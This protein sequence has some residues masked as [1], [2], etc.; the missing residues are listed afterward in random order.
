[1][2]LEVVAI[3]LL[4]LFCIFVGILIGMF[5]RKTPGGQDLSEDLREIQ[6]R[7]EEWQKIAATQQQIE[8][9]RTELSNAHVTLS[10][11]DTLI[12]NLT[13]FTQQNF[14]PEVS[15]Q[16]QAAMTNITQVQQILTDVLQN[17]RQETSNTDQRHAQLLT[18]VHEAQKALS[19][20]Q[21]TL[22][23]ISENI[24][25]NQREIN[26]ILQG[27]QKDIVSAKDTVQNINQHINLLISLSQIVE[28]VERNVS[29][30]TR[31][32]T[33]RRSGQ[34]GEQIVQELLKYL[35]QDWLERDKSINGGKVEFAIRLPG[36][37]FIPLDSKFVK[38]E[39]VLQLEK[40]EDTEKQQSIIKQIKDDVRKKALE[41]STKYINHT[42]CIGFG[43][44]AV[45]DS[46]Y[47][48]CRD[49]VITTAK[50][51][52]I[53]V[54][55]YSLLLPFILSLYLLA[56][57][58]NISVNIGDKIQAFET[59][60]NLL[61]NVKTNLEKMANELKSLKNQRDTALQN[62]EQALLLLSRI[63]REEK[64]LYIQ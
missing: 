56:Q 57:R 45:P 10:Q 26:I 36:G 13:N 63:I 1:M 18:N 4:T 5:I 53:V 28:R 64:G 61:V 58:L 54:I 2:N 52:R 60:N 40:D 49:V 32:L 24:R 7:L 48:L 55:P 12:Q 3:V 14:Q 19:S 34:A 16:L 37:F 6:K 43:I 38:P 44:A 51:N 47:E 17:M 27:M 25:N 8:Q 50:A 22:N 33:G 15:R 9:V 41:I 23:E 11:V 35:P 30:L 59:A 42:E 31:I 21:S 20:L 46:V 62:L 39:L 29:E